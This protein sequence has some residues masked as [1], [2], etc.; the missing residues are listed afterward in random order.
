MK[1]ILF[2]PFERYSERVLLGIGLAA[3]IPAIFLGAYFDTRFDG[4]LDLHFYP[5]TTVNDVV[6][7]LAVGM[8]ALFVFLFA[9]GLWI[10]RKTR[11]VDILST[12]LVAKIPMYVLVFFNAGG[13]LS[14]IGEEL[15]QQATAQ[16]SLSPGALSIVILVL[17]IIV[18]LLMVVWSV[19]LLY[20]GY[21][22]AANAKGGKAIVLFIAALLLAEIASK[23]VLYFVAVP[24]KIA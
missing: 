15:M 10:N 22:V 17:F 12:V 9:A 21:K 8:A 1:T 19:A 14:G 3:I 24:L 11:A 20:N 13:T 6:I 2:R 4:A 23:I 7:D 16:Q 5:G 18:L